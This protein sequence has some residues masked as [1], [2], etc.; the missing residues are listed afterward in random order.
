MVKGG[1]GEQSQRTKEKATVGKGPGSPRG[2]GKAGGGG[3]GGGVHFPKNT[4]IRSSKGQQ[5][6]LSDPTTIWEGGGALLITALKKH[7]EGFLPHKVGEGAREQNK[8]AGEE[9]SVNRGGPFYQLGNFGRRN[10]GSCE[11]AEQVKKTGAK[12]GRFLQ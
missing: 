2:F 5:G 7:P 11:T 8:P 4:T 6:P 1:K 9:H 3:G 12:S 10:A